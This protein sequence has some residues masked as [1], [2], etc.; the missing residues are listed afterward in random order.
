VLVHRWEDDLP[1]GADEHRLV[2]WLARALRF[3][4]RAR[5]PVNCSAT[6]VLLKEKVVQLIDAEFAFFGLLKD[7]VIVA[8]FIGETV[9]LAK[10]RR[11]TIGLLLLVERKPHFLHI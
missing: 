11:H 10:V 5:V 7:W 1:V 4:G 2:L 3:L 8:I 9:A 6:R